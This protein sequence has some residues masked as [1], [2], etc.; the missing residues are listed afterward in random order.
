MTVHNHGTEEGKGLSCR[1]RIVNGELKGECMIEL[2]PEKLRE[3]ADVVEAFN[4]RCGRLDPDL[5]M[6]NPASLRRVADDIEAKNA[7]KA[8][9]DRAV[10]AL[11]KH[12]YEGFDGW[13]YAPT[14]DR[15]AKSLYDAGWR[16]T[17]NAD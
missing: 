12:I 3:A 10:E 16:K 13:M 2:T 17:T 7:K 1:E 4:Y 8:E 11:S 9:R 14:A 5:E 6:R 15:I